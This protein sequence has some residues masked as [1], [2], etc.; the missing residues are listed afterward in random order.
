M[1]EKV[2]VTDTGIQSSGLPRDYMEAVAE[3]IWNGFDA[4]ASIID[5]TFETNEIDTIHSLSITDNGTGIDYDQLKETFGNFNDSI[6]KATFQ[7]TSSVI[8]GSKGRG[9]FSFSAFSGKALWKTVYKD[10]TT[11][12]LNA[13]E[14]TITKNSKDY[15]DP[16]DKRELSKGNTGTIVTFTDLFDVTGFSF[17]SDEFKTFLEREFGW[18]L[19]LNREKEYQIR[20]NGVVL[21]YQQLIAET[22][23]GTLPLKDAEGKEHFFKI[24]FVRWSE[25]IGDKFFFYFLN[26]HQKELFK[27]L[28]SFNNNAIGFYHSVYVESRYFDAFNPQDNELSQNL[29]ERTRQ[30][31]VFKMLMN[32]LHELVRLR[33]KAFVDGEAAEKLVDNYEKNGIIPKLQD[34]RKKKALLKVV[35]SLY[36]I[37]PRLFQGLNKEQQRINV[38]LLGILLEA[39]MKEDIVELISH[40]VPLSDEDRKLLR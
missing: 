37:E 38:G 15:F 36:C 33:Q 17:Q 23:I 30:H 13:Y 24:T 29:F 2:S 6:K 1:K 10:Q 12:K 14:I 5:I 34:G 18:F 3:Y 4:A 32:H 28:T 9:R 27:D 8:K 19:M 39:G 31:G 20:I 16:H 40:I 7:K 21:P 26:S 25:R 11:G 35:K 22:D